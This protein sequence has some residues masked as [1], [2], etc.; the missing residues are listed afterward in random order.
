MQ[1]RIKRGG[2]EI[3]GGARGAKPDC[4]G[5]C[6]MMLTSPGG[7]IASVKRMTFLEMNC[8]FSWSPF[9]LLPICFVSQQGLL[10]ILWS[11]PQPFPGTEDQ[12]ML[13]NLPQQ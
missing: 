3:A 1:W 4:K 9:S 11:L 6:L 13:F 2:D 7:R 10:P 12:L 5:R 8:G